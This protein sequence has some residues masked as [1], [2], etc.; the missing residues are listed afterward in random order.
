MHLIEKVELAAEREYY[1]MEH[2][3]Y[4]F[5]IRHLQLY[6]PSAPHEN[7]HDPAVQDNKT[8]FQ[9]QNVRDFVTADTFLVRGWVNTGQWTTPFLRLSYRGGPDTY[10][11]GATGHQL[12]DSI[13]LWVKVGDVAT[14]TL[15]TVPYNVRRD[16]YE[17]ELWGYPGS[18]L[19]QQLD[20]KGRASLDRGEL[21]LRSDLI[22]GSLADFN[23]EGKDEQYMP[24]LATYS[25]MHPINSLHLEVAWAD[26]Q[27]RHWDSNNGSN[28]HYEFNMV[29]RGWENYLGVGMSAHPHGGTGFLEYRNLLSNYFRYADRRE[30]GRKLESWNMDAQGS[31]DHQ[32]EIESF[33]A[34]DYMDLHLLKANSGIGLHR[35]RDNQEVFLVMRGQGLMVVGDWCKLPERERCFEV[36]TLREGHFALLKGGN[37]HALMNSRDEE[38][39]LFMFGGYD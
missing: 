32:T 36:R 34:V 18:D 2:L 25:T 20:E 24:E 33:M 16:C 15:L 4:L 11:S 12:G 35:H 5:P 9:K 8:D 14:P 38:M 29:V 3:H 39:H 22:R 31:K 26:R 37:L 27:E 21:Q 6:S 17:V 23:R 10:L 7:L 28:F 1:M 13:K 19:R 30:M